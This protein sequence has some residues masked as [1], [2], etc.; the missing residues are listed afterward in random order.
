VNFYNN[1]MQISY[2]E[3]EELLD[4]LKA[5]STLETLYANDLRNLG[6]RLNKY[7]DNKQNTLNEAYSA[8]R[9]FF[10]IHSELSSNFSKQLTSDII[11]NINKYLNISKE[12]LRNYMNL[13][14]NSEKELK[15]ITDS[16]S[17]VWFSQIP[18]YNSKKQG[19]TKIYKTNDENWSSYSRKCKI[20]FKNRRSDEEKNGEVFFIMIFFFY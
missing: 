14:K 12:D 16:Q 3:T 20:D 4:I 5:R 7:A 19:E 18:I 10:S 17:K 11:E 13:G 8:L 9:S 15:R 2:Q 1:K 6:A